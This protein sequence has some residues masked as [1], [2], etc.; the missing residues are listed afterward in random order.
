MM[1]QVI[2]THRSINTMLHGIFYQIYPKIQFWYPFFWATLY[3]LCATSCGAQGTRLQMLDGVF[4][5]VP[6]RDGQI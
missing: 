2:F 1:S 5:T 3:V 4:T 6:C